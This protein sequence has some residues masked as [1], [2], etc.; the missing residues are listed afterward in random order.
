MSIAKKPFVF[1]IFYRE[2]AG[3]GGGSGAS[4]P[5][6]MD[7]RIKNTFSDIFTELA[8]NMP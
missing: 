1:F 5:F 3:G 8:S 4:A 2:M 6:P 7:P